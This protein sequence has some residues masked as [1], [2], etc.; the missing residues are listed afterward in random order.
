MD[1]REIVDQLNTW[2]HAYYTLDDPLVSD[3]EYDALYDE[4]LRRER[5]TGK[6]LFLSLIHI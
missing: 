1:M 4:L 2:A 6:V 3:K 5:E